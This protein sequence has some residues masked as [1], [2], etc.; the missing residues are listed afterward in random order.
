MTRPFVRARIVGL[1]MFTLA[2][3]LSCNSGKDSGGT[4]PPPPPPSDWSSLISTTFYAT[5]GAGDEW[6]CTQL[7]VPADMYITGFRTTA[8]LGNYRAFLT[9]SDKKDPVNPLGHFNCNLLTK[10]DRLVYASGLNTPDI[11]FP[12]GVAVH[13]KAGQF[14]ML[15]VAS[16]D[17]A[18]TNETG[19]TE[20]L[21]KTAK[22]AD[23]TQDADAVIAMQQGRTVPPGVDGYK[24]PGGCISQDDYHV[25]GILPLMNPYAL[26]QMM[27]I[28]D[29]AN[30]GDTIENVAYSTA[31][32]DY[33]FLAAPL[34]EHSGNTIAETCTYDNTTGATLE[35]FEEVNAPI[36][37]AVMYRYPAPDSA[38]SFDCPTP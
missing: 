12:A 34:S 6:G 18:D 15:T 24:V 25:F 16:F 30:P 9:L 28:F 29:G 32:Q 31:H 10:F 38:N 3:S 11:T 36:C 21:V 14:L 2:A 26:T 7:Q 1:A 17:Q 35:G 33:S 20:V 4:G 8:G 27:V 13:L 22:A 19:T 37:D 23:I 5:V